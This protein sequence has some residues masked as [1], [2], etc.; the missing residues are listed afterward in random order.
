MRGNQNGDPGGIP[1]FIILLIGYIFGGSLYNLLGSH[2]LSLSIHL[3]LAF[4]KEI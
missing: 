1:G 3:Q 4:R 2:F